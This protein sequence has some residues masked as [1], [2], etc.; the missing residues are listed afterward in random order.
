MSVVDFET[1]N[2]TDIADAERRMGLVLLVF[3]AFALVLVVAVVGV[4]YWVLA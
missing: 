1:D 3:A 4:A 2:A